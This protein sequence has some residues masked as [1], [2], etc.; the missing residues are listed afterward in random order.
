ML[1]IQQMPLI[2]NS[3][4][5]ALLFTLQFALSYSIS[6]VNDNNIITK[7]DF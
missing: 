3:Y 7:H 1:I 5:F 4:L 6:L 2:W